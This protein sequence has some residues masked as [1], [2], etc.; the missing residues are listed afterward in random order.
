MDRNDM[1]KR[2]LETDCRGGQGPPRAVAPRKK[3]TRLVTFLKFF[4][5]SVQISDIFV[6][7]ICFKLINFVFQIFPFLFPNC[8]A[9]LKSYI[10]PIISTDLAWILRPL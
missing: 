5:A 8:S 9:G 3:K 7:I 1:K 4:Y 6:F 2:S 10:L